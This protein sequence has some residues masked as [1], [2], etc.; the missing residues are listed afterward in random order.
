MDGPIEEAVAETKASGPGGTSISPFNI[1]RMPK[2]SEGKV[3]L[4]SA[5]CHSVRIPTRCFLK[6]EVNNKRLHLDLTSTL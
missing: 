3:A 6:F 1:F 5:M 2:N 4:E